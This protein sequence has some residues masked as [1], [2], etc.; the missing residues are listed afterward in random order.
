MVWY[1]WNMC[2][3]V[4]SCYNKCGDIIESYNKCGDII[5]MYM[6]YKMVII[7]VIAHLVISNWDVQL[8]KGTRIWHVGLETGLRH[9][10]YG[11]CMM[12]L[13]PSWSE[14]WTVYLRGSN[15]RISKAI[16]KNGLLIGHPIK[17]DHLGVSPF[18]ETR[19]CGL[20]SI[21]FYPLVV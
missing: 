16:H 3:C 5:E 19:T 21:C 9:D 7:I 13:A 1:L 18:T 6:D 11:I 8:T 2:V 4:W 14:I 20:V 10:R 15:M 12:L 17:M